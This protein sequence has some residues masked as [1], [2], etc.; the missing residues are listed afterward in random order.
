MAEANLPAGSTSQL[1]LI[2]STPVKFTGGSGNG[3]LEGTAALEL[4]RKQ[5]WGGV[6]MD[7]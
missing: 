5:F 4:R 2:A 7:Y 3:K 1:V 6:G